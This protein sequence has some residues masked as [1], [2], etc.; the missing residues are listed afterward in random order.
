MLL[1]TMDRR[2]IEVNRLGA[3]SEVGTSYDVQ[4]TVVGH[5]KGPIYPADDKEWFVVVEHRWPRVNTSIDD[6]VFL[7]ER[8]RTSPQLIGTIRRIIMVRTVTR[9]TIL[10]LSVSKAVAWVLPPVR[11]AAKSL[12]LNLAGNLHGEGACFLPL[13][14]MESD[15]YAPRI[16]QVR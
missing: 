3:P 16:I 12:V 9:V 7:T 1:L 11:S 8:P 13:Q 6:T 10:L 4:V 2:N 5:Q 15:Y 14:Q